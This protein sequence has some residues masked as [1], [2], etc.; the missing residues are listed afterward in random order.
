MVNEECG[1]KE[2]TKGITDRCVI[3]NRFVCV[4]HTNRTYA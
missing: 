2:C 1:I 4:D 3:C